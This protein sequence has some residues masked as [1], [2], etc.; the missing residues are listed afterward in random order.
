MRSA[1]PVD[2]EGDEPVANHLP[3][4]RE[5]PTKNCASRLF[6]GH[7]EYDARVESSLA[8]TCDVGLDRPTSD[9]PGDESRFLQFVEA[10]GPCLLRRGLIGIFCDEFQIDLIREWQDRIV[11]PETLVL[12]PESG[13]ETE[14][15]LDAV[16]GV[17]E[18]RH[19]IDEMVQLQ[20][21]GHLDSPRPRPRPE[22]VEA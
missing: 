22:S 5:L 12:S 14:T 17:H 16:D 1:P 3:R 18:A 20:S 11:G 9:G 8:A 6:P 2:D 7:R 13:G 10:K 4:K 15:S 19:R 21:M